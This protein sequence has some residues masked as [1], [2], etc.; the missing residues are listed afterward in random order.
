MSP[1]RLWPVNARRVH[2]HLLPDLRQDERLA[3][4]IA[5]SRAVADRYGCLTVV[6]ERWLHVPVAAVADFGVDRG[7]V[8]NTLVKALNRFPAFSMTLGSVIVGADDVVLD[9]DGDATRASPLVVLHEMIADALRG[10]GSPVT[11]TD[12]VFPP[13]LTI[14]YGRGEADSGLIASEIRGQVR[15]GPATFTVDNVAVVDARQDP[16]SLQMS[17]REIARIGLGAVG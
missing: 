15:N 14:A 16:V 2:V 11:G 9:C 12:E 1:V 3:A 10:I 8:T 5:R 7:V 4:L 17:W 6:E 13:G